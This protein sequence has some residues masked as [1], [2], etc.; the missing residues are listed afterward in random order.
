[1]VRTNENWVMD[2]LILDWDGVVVSNYH[3]IFFLYQ[4]IYVFY[5][6]ISI[7]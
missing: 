2:I 6:I 4:S 7:M 3:H 1:M 5:T